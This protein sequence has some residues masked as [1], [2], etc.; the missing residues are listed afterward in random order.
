MT[1]A[2]A[3]QPGAAESLLDGNAE[4]PELAELAE[5]LYVETLFVVRPLGLRV[6]FSFAERTNELTKG[7]MLSRW[8]EQVGHLAGLPRKH[9]ERKRT[10]RTGPFRQRRRPRSSSR[11]S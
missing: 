5:Q 1:A 10:G 11:C 7:A 6:D 9:I 4:K 8:I 3:I 2:T